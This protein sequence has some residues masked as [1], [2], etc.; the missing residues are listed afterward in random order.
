MKPTCGCCAGIQ[1]ATPEPEAN[2]PGLPAI[3]YRVG[4]HATFLESMI[5]RLSNLYLDVPAVNGSGSLTRLWRLKELTTRDPSDPSIALL[6][7]WAVVADVLSF[8]EERIANE[9]YLPTATERRSILELARLV[10]YKLRPGVSASVFLAFTV[11]NG[12][13]GVLPMGT[14]SQ[15]IPGTGETAQFFETSYDLAARDTWNNLKPRLTRPQLITLN[16]DYATDAIT[17]D[18]IYFKGMS[19]NLNPGNALLFVLGNGPNEQVLRKV[20]SVDVQGD[21]KRT[22]VTLEEP[23]V[24]ITGGQPPLDAVKPVLQPFI[25]EAAS[26]FADSDLAG[27][28]TGAL[29]QLLDNLAA[30]SPTSIV[31]MNIEASEMV[32]SVIPQIQSLHDISLRRKF[33]RLEP[34]LA[35]LLGAVND[36]ARE[37]SQTILKGGVSGG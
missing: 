13:Q 17:R 5:A 24:Q 34:W 21:Q 36:L 37:L 25:D 18:M 6:D 7:A 31:P 16:S 11:A 4:T 2:R 29:K 14:R 26:V 15:S 8:Y 30:I 35:G 12:F 33:T 10:G 9:G 22:E 32:T 1:I 23:I 19:T 3:A 27:Q 20:G 28:S